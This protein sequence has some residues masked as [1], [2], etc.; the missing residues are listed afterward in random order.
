MQSSAE[1]WGSQP[2]SYDA[3]NAEHLFASRNVYGIPDVP[4]API[5]AR[6]RWIAPYRQR[7]R[8]DHGLSDGAA[9]FFLDDYRFETVWSRPRK[10]L[11][12]LTRF[13]TVLTPDFSLFRDW[14]H[15][16]QVWNTYR[17]RWCGAFWSLHGL[18]VI[19]TASWSTP[20]S[21]DFAFCGLPRHSLIVLSTVGTHKDPAARAL[22]L[23]G[24]SALVER[25]EPSG[26]MCYGQPHPEILDLAEIFVYPSRWQGLRQARSGADDGR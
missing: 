23:A 8:S 13:D 10:A 17:S 2:G 25:V 14:P 15:A 18:R 3:L 11:Q 26:V 4:H 21:Y 7:L 20:D 5:S 19:P 22:F 16:L 9:H 12:Y 1:K 24:F 6:P